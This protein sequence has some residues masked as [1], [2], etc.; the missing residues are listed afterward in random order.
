MKVKTLL[1]FLLF[2]QFGGCIKEVNTDFDYKNKIA[3]LARINTSAKNNL[4]Y[5]S[6]NIAMNDSAD[7]YY[8]KYLIKDAV[9]Q[10]SDDLGHSAVISQLQVDGYYMDSSLLQFNEGR[11]YALSIITTDGRKASSSMYIP[12]AT[13]IDAVSFD[14]S[15][16]TFDGGSA[17][18][19]VRTINFS[20]DFAASENY[21]H[22]YADVFYSIHCKGVGGFDSTFSRADRFLLNAAAMQ[23]GQAS[24]L[25]SKATVRY[26]EKD[27]NAA[28]V[29]FDSM[30]Y[31]LE[32][33]D[34][35]YSKFVNS[36]QKQQA[37]ANDPF[38]EP[39]LLYSNIIDGVGVFSAFALRSKK[40]IL[41][42]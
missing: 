41:P 20:L 8:L 9:I 28:R 38:A 25:S 11:T 21:V 30:V 34:G 31:Y 12:R 42:H 18:N 37:V 27:L 17:G 13:T 23:Y 2:L 29:V 16:A 3:V 24:T 22:A 39:S 6:N 36:V 10:V 32:T 19:I 33:D 14:T 5:L 7:Q 15:S 1:Y 40:V 35:T 4:L 26:Y